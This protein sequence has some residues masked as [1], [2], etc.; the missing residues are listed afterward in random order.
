MNF[1]DFIVSVITILNEEKSRPSSVS[2]VMRIETEDVLAKEI[3]TNCDRVSELLG[4]IS[5]L[6]CGFI[7]YKRSVS[8]GA[9]ISY[10]AW[11][12]SVI[13]YDGLKNDRIVERWYNN[14]GLTTSDGRLIAL[15]SDPVWNGISFFGFPFPPF[16]VSCGYGIDEVDFDECVDLGLI[17]ESFKGGKRIKAPPN[18]DWSFMLDDYMRGVCQRIIQVISFEE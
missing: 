16:D 10:P 7:E 4:V 13:D 1:H 2:S 11:E 8:D 6:R 12:L 17:K 18:P 5:G 3:L 15:K 14:G 9:R